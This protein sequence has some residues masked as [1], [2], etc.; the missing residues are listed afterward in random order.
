MGHFV[1]RINRTEH[2]S[3]SPTD[4]LAGGGSLADYINNPDLSGVVGVEN[5]YWVITGDTVSEMSQGEKD[6][7]DAA[8]LE[9]QR[10]STAAQLDVVE[11][12]LRAFALV[13]LDE[14]NTLRSQH[15]LAD[16]TIAQLKAGVRARLGD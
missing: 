11:D 5:K 9:A 2:R 6:A 7:V 16:R 4:L 3:I 15:G 10:D 12:V 14:I 1:H 13:V 8:A